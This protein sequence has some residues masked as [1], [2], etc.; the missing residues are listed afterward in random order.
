MKAVKIKCKAHVWSFDC[1]T[2]SC[3]AT[4]SEGVTFEFEITDAEGFVSMPDPKWPDEYLYCNFDF[5]IELEIPATI[6]VTKDER[7]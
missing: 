4:I 1:E 7:D 2:Q 3:T 6:T 5:E